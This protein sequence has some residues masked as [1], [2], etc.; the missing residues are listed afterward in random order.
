MK[1][2]EREDEAARKGPTITATTTIAEDTTEKE[3]VVTPLMSYIINRYKSSSGRARNGK[4]STGDGR[5][6]ENR[7]RLQ[8]IPEKPAIGKSAAE[9]SGTGKAAP[10]KRGRGSKKDEKNAKGKANITDTTSG[11][12]QESG[13]P[14]VFKSVAF[15]ISYASRNI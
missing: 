5:E 2:I 11:D 7:K 13:Q 9:V 14:G 15:M 8:V 1:E 6:K 10:G 12:K 4:G 3:P